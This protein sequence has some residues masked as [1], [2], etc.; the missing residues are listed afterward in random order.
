MHI[1]K[2]L[3]FNCQADILYI[4]KCG[5]VSTSETFLERNTASQVK[6]TLQRLS[7]KKTSTSAKYFEDSQKLKCNMQK[8]RVPY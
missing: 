6:Y 1:A 8:F 2:K 3:H 5:A 4:L 7:K